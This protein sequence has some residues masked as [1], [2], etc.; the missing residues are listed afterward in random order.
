[1]LTALT[2]LPSGALANC[3]L[4]FIGREP[5]D[6]KRAEQQH[7]EYRAALEACGARVIALP[8]Q[9][10]LPDSVFVED[11]AVVVKELAV[12]TNLGVASRRPEAGLIEPELARFRRIVRLQP[13][14]TLEGGDVLQIGR[15]VYVGLS[16]RTNA[17]GV[18]Q[19]NRILAPYGYAVTA[20]AVTG[21]L[22]LKTACTP[23]DDQT[24]LANPDWVD[25]AVLADYSVVPIAADEPWAANVL[26][27]GQTLV[28]SAAFPKTRAL[29]QARD[30]SVLP[31]DLSE[32][33]KAEAG[34]TCLSLILA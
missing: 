15:Q 29:V 24:I 22:H 6:V 4:T 19:V 28:M 3:E 32:F 10:P 14:A 18:E 11:A 31:V 21:C 30:Y 5:I 20:V 26:R 9:D 12:I 2:R 16:T 17:A 34:V 8:A 23:L 13:P 25:P 27:L 33:A 7:R 1:M